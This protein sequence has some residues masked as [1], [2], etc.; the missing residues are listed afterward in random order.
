MSFS[1][2]SRAKA[3]LNPIGVDL[4]SPIENS[5]KIDLEVIPKKLEKFGSNLVR[6]RAE[7]V[8]LG[9]PK[10]A[11]LYDLRKV[12]SRTGSRDR[13]LS[14]DIPFS[15]CP[16]SKKGAVKRLKDSSWI[17][18]GKLEVHDKKFESHG[19][20]NG[21]SHTHK[22]NGERNAIQSKLTRFW[23]TQQPPTNIAEN[24]VGKQT[25]QSKPRKH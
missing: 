1:G 24:S 17:R 4:K 5:D 14:G 8:D 21:R 3:P 16:N 6:N 25:T 18:V 2:N 20:K 22:N 9:P 11:I 13:L 15:P 7:N 19:M 23:S 12:K 10:P